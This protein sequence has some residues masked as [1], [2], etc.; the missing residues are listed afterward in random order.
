METPSFRRGI[1]F[2]LGMCGGILMQNKEA[3]G[4]NNTPWDLKRNYELLWRAI[5]PHHFEFLP[6]SCSHLCF[7]IWL[8]SKMSFVLT[9]LTKKREVDTII[10]DT[11]EKVLVLRFGRPTDRACLI[12]DDIVCLLFMLIFCILFSHKN[13]ILWGYGG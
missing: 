3:S 13:R 7:E 4:F 9:T 1:L 12:L 2:F 8:W 10:R 11:L 5:L 6:N